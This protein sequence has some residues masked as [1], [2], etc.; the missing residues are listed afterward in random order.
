MSDVV[1]QNSEQ[2]HYHQTITIPRGKRGRYGATELTIP[3]SAMPVRTHCPK[4]HAILN[5]TD[6]NPACPFCKIDTRISTATPE[7]LASGYGVKVILEEPEQHMKYLLWAQLSQADYDNLRAFRSGVNPTFK[8]DQKVLI[9][10]CVHFPEDMKSGLVIACGDG[11]SIW[12]G[13][14]KL[15]N[16]WGID[17]HDYSEQWEDYEIDQ[18]CRVSDYRT[19]PYKKNMFD[20]VTCIQP[21]HYESEPDIDRFINECIRVGTRDI[22]FEFTTTLERDIFWYL[23]KLT[24]RS[25]IPVVVGESYGNIATL[26]VT[27]PWGS[28]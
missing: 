28:K 3:E 15:R 8:V 13:R 11:G 25:L 20:H 2:S 26:E 18:Y 23:Q 22:H 5:I 6:N 7:D 12:A 24:D 14:K 19:L 4:C 17:E 27:I 21:V 1:S 9:Y 10:A 16:V